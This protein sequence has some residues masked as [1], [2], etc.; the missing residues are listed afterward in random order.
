MSGGRIATPS[1]MILI[2]ISVATGG[3]LRI[4]SFFFAGE[5]I[6]EYRWDGDAPPELEGDL[7]A[8]HASI[9]PA[10]DREEG[11]ATLADG[12]PVHWVLARR[13][14]ATITLLYSHGNGPH[15]GRFWDR[16]ERLW[17]LG[18]HVLIYDYPGY[19][20]S[21]GV[22]SEQGMYD[23]IF[24]V[25]HQTIPSLPGIDRGRVALYGHS[26]GAGPALHLAAVL[27]RSAQR[28]LSVIAESTWCSV[29]AQIQ[30]GAWLDLP[31][32]LLSDLE[33]DN[34]ARIAELGRTL[35]VLLLHG[36]L[37]RVA[38]PRQARMLERAAGGPVELHVIDGA[39][40]TDLPNVAGADYT[41]WIH[42]HLDRA[43]R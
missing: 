20:R 42:A 14:G 37:D 18:F 29:E 16:V 41:T 38:H 8:P 32:E 10:A 28:P 9:V 24:A 34:C 19:G 3:C 6:A 39:G 5:P 36:S 13:P 7:G 15:L 33:I 11:F 21:G 30:D 4:D 1:A 43:S 31:G 35:P 12:T 26:L 22:A 25:W 23:A 27:A 17:E 2:A 40:H